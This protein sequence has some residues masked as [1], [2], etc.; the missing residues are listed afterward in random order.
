MRPGKMSMVEDT[1]Q[2][3][4]QKSSFPNLGR[5]TARDHGAAWFVLVV[6]ACFALL[7][8]A[9]GSSI[10]PPEPRDR[11]DGLLLAAVQ[12]NKPADVADL[13]RRGA[14][15]N[16]M[17]THP[18]DESTALLIAAR[19]GD[20]DIA[21]AL[22]A[23]GA[24]VNLRQHG[25]GSW[26]GLTPIMA[27]AGSD[28]TDLLRLLIEH[29]GNL[30]RR[31]GLDGTGPTA[32]YWASTYGRIGPVSLLLAEGAS[33]E[34][35]DLQTAISEGHSEIARRLLEAGADPWWRFSTGATVL[36][37]AQRSPVQSRAKMVAL[38]RLFRGAQHPPPK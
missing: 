26:E 20:I 13:L 5:L 30:N 17:T 3:L 31:T 11:L 22:I 7:V 15:P 21:R 12:A 1:G 9:C 8:T 18:H 33:I 25:T 38:V 37:Q 24:D 2:V 14:S 27:A 16:A 36:E 10:Q 4:L 35:R 32:L 6:P 34:P 19:Q 29:G 23:A 28:R